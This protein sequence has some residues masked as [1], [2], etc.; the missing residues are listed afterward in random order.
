MADSPDEIDTF[1]SAD[2]ADPRLKRFFIRIVERITGQRYLK[3]L[4]EDNRAHPVPG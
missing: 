2:P 1:S 3:W 4:Y